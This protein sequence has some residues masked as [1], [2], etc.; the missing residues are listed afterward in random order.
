MA[1]ASE[2]SREDVK[3]PFEDAVA[4]ARAV[5]P[6]VA[7][8]A[9]Q[10]ERDRRLAPAVLDA[11]HGAGLF[12]MLL[13]RVY[14]GSEVDPVTFAEAIET[15]AAQD[16]STAWC[17]CQGNGCSMSAAYLPEAV[18]RQVWGDDPRAVLA[19][20]P[21]KGCRGVPDGDDYV[22]TGDW[23][24]ASGGHHATWL[25]GECVICNG[26][27][28]PLKND[29][30]RPVLRTLLFRSDLA[31]WTDAWDV[32]GLRGT[33][34]D[35]YA[36]SEL[37]VPKDF[38]LSR[39]DPAERRVDTP[40]YR[41]PA[42]AL[43]AAGFSGTAIGIAQSMLDAFLELA[44]GKTPRL[45]SRTLAEDG[46]VQ[47]ELALCSVRLASAR[48]FVRGELA[49]I[50]DE[51]LSTGQL[52]VDQRM[53]IRLATTHAIH[54][55]KSVG[56]SVYDMAGATAIFAANGFERRFRDLRTVTQQLQGR[57]SHYGTVGA[58]MLGH[59]PDMSVV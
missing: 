55:A 8:H 54:E 13:P 57:R 26:D 9:E 23:M 37:R 17:L 19:W 42:M 22:L 49:D 33:G 46:M 40:L 29:D 16:A 4:A 32:M 7:A 44:G 39:D 1:Q 20:G 50:W 27:G 5:A 6:V 38:A 35:A 52:T 36:V 43:Y 56:E 28:E 41:F 15:I 48:S 2:N 10:T 31:A 25:G 18:S 58:Y 11:L 53:R 59:E 12:R 47:G 24:F 14:G 30:G 34:S 45:Q 3:P 51:V 21:G